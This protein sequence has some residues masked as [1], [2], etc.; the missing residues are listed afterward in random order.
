MGKKK[1]KDKKG[2]F[3]E[4]KAFITRGNIVDMAVGIII[5]GAFSAIVTALTGKIIMPVINLIIS[6]ATGGDGIN[7]ITILNGEPQFVVQDGVEVL[8][9]KCIYID[10]GAF[11]ETI[12]N[13]LLIALVLFF[14]IKVINTAH[15]K[16]EELKAKQLE[17]YYEKHPEERPVPPEP[18][19]P[20][21]TEL[22]VLNEI[23]DL[24]KEKQEKKAEKK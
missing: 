11:I 12:I 16:S 20:V 9:A 21:P 19:E 10:W 3:A 24:L 7:L 1:N 2:L 17:A 14:I 18:G 4:F 22:D 5:G 23:R 6:L 8:N 13:F 15:K